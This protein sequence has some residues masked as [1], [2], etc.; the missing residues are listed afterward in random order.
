MNYSSNQITLSD[1]F[2]HQKYVFK[3]R[4]RNS[5]F[6]KWLASF[7]LPPLEKKEKAILE[8]SE[9]QEKLSLI[10]CLILFILSSILTV[11]QMFNIIELYLNVGFMEQPLT[12]IY[13]YFHLKNNSKN[14]CNNSYFIK[15][16]KI[17]NPTWSSMYSNLDHNFTI[18]NYFT[19]FKVNITIVFVILLCNPNVQHG[20]H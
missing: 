12:L 18:F 2:S 14:L 1:E 15:Y 19:G 8:L 5:N 16:F 4:N 6:W 13:P 10:R 9:N 17:Y 7:R 3:K 20:S 11:N